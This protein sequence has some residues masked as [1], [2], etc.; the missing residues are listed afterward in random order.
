MATA[1]ALRALPCSQRC[2]APSRSVVPGVK[3]AA[4]QGRVVVAAG[5]LRLVRFRGAAS[6]ACRRCAARRGAAGCA[7][8]VAAADTQAADAL[9]RWLGSQGVD[10][11]AVRPAAVPEGLGLV[12]TRC[13]QTRRDAG[14]R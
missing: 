8:V 4:Q 11:A 6:R 10:T 9:W 12:C 2:A 7:L 1:V 3:L 14:A 5:A 13:V